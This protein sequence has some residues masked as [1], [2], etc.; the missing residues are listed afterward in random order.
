MSHVG[1]VLQ[2]PTDDTYAW[3]DSLV[4][5]SWLR[6]NPRRF[7]T[8]VGNR[9]SEV[10][11]IIPPN[12]W[13]HVKGTDNPADAASRGIFPAELIKNDLWWEG[14]QWLRLRES[15]WPDQPSLLEKPEPQ[16]EKD[17][18]PRL[19]LVTMEE[20]SIL[21]RFSYTRLKRVTAW[22]FRFIKNCGCQAPMRALTGALT[23]EELQSA[24]RYWI[25]KVSVKN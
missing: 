1:N 23:T 25:R 4:V 19:A 24:E 18:E 6:R 13:R 14:P 10:I 5:L 17:D 12:R 3:T 22:V 11:E 9:V 8:F 2:I 20:T 16:E 21:D 7:K 15:R